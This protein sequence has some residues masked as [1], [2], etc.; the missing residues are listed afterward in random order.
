MRYEERQ[1]EE[2]RLSQERAREVEQEVINHIWYAVSHG[3]F[4]VWLPSPYYT[5][6]EAFVENLKSLGY[7][8]EREDDGWEIKW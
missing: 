2:A 8:V 3:C 4:R 1:G 7:E 5:L 6:S